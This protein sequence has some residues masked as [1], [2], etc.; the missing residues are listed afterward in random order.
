ME[1]F[2]ICQA[3]T[4]VVAVRNH[5]PLP[6]LVQEMERLTQKYQGHFIR[7]DTMNIDVS[8]Q[9]LREWTASGKSLRYYVPDEVIAYM[10]EHDIYLGGE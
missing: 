2:R 4:L 5:T 9:L 8:S 3:C 10:K 7:L 1:P 6:D